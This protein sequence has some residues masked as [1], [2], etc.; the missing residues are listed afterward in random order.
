MM[1]IKSGLLKL[2][3][4]SYTLMINSISYEILGKI[5]STK[6]V[7]WKNLSI[8]KYSDIYLLGLKWI[9]W[10]IAV[11]SIFVMILHFYLL[12]L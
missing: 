10:I 8:I 12:Q 11:E 3:Q 9:C 4:Y 7:I 2:K 6:A 1:D 5:I